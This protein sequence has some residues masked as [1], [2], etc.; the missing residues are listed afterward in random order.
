MFMLMFSIGIKMHKRKW[1]KNEYSGAKSSYFVWNKSILHVSA[2]LN[3][4]NTRFWWSKMHTSI[5]WIQRSKRNH[6][7][8]KWIALRLSFSLSVIQIFIFINIILTRY[9]EYLCIFPT[10]DPFK[11]RMAIM[12]I[13]LSCIYVECEVLFYEIRRIISLLKHIFENFMRIL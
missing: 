1:A 3:D 6:D 5:C 12:L 11:L 2:F 13:E 7:W 9:G 10:I 4:W 8:F